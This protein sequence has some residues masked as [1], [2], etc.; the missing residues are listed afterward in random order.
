MKIVSICMITYNHEKFIR[1]AIESVLAQKT[2][3]D[4]ELVIG[5]DCSTDNTR[6]ICIEYAEKHQGKIKLLLHEENMG[7]IPNFLKTL[8]SCSG[9]YVAMLEGDD[10]WTHPLKLQKQVDFL[11]AN[12]D[13]A[14]C[15]HNMNVIYE[16][17]TKESH[18]SNPPDQ[19]EDSTIEDLAHGNYI[20]TASCVFRNRLIGEF[21][22][23]FSNCS[24]GDYPLHMLN[25]RSGKIRYIPDVM[26]VYRV[27]QEG[28][29]ENKDIIFRMS[30]WVEM[31]DRMKDQFSPGINKI[32]TEVQSR[33]SEYLMIY[34]R[35]QP[36]KCR[37]YLNKLTEN[38]LDIFANLLDEKTKTL[39]Y[40]AGNMS[41][42]FVFLDNN[43]FIQK[44]IELRETN[45]H[46]TFDLKGIT[47]IKQLRF[48]P[49]ENRICRLKIISIKFIA[50]GE[51]IIDYPLAE[52]T[53]NGK[54]NAD[55]Y[56]SFET[57]DPMIYIHL[58]G[59]MDSI[60]IKGVCELEPIHRVDELLRAKNEV[61]NSKYAEL[62]QKD[63]EL[64]Q[65]NEIINTK[66]VELNQKNKEISQMNA[67]ISW[68]ITSPGRFIAGLFKNISVNKNRK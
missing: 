20:Y 46:F 44:S 39:N 68:R 62:N 38:G 14:I 22:E 7:M 64:S 27:H 17:N 43:S 28:F 35:E 6:A 18:L 40:L 23:W 4:Y 19:K 51:K 59:S 1:Q 21:P 57:L 60:V 65:K 5:E 58:P 67:S 54:L 66:N 63:E 9:K 29:W 53:S 52:L 56:F 55:G 16:E 50:P 8:N 47:G 32:L 13:F 15:H 2:D 25:A 31:I 3:F 11:E 26:G 41:S 33:N 12:E 34:Y 10:Y 61:I 49:T 48:D 30:N 42:L 45:F 37:Y 24:I 36:D